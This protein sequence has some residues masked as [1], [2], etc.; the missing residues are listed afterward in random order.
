MDLLLL[1]IFPVKVDRKSYLLALYFIKLIWYQIW[2]ARC[3]HRF[4][5]KMIQSRTIIKHTESEIKPR[6]TLCFQAHTS[7]SVKQMQTWR[8]K[9]TLCTL[10]KNNWFSNSEP[11]RNST[12]HLPFCF[13]TFGVPERPHTQKLPQCIITVSHTVSTYR[14][15]CNLDCNPYPWKSKTVFLTCNFNLQF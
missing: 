9:D 14:Q 12:N 6:I 8:A 15:L 5:Q 11:T 7:V 2:L 1:R 3:S 4:H 10:D 13:F